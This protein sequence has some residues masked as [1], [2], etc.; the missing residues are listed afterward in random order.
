MTITIINDCNAPNAVGRQLTR[1]T[2]LFHAP[3]SFVAISNNL[4]GPGD[5]ELAGNIIDILDAH[6]DKP[7]V[8]L[9]NFAPRQGQAKRWP[10]GTPFGY[11]W[12]RQILVATTI[13]G[14]ALS[15]VKK[16]NI[17]T[18]ISVV[19]IPSVL[20]SWSMSP[21]GKKANYQ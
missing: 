14:L 18:A 21:E 12:Y 11:F 1:A 16:L 19:D 5:L 17:T 3:S 7:G 6:E 13:D 9:A 4:N 2:T 20:A 8:I 10:N 15:L